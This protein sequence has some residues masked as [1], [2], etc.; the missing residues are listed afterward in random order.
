MQRLLYKSLD[1]A[2]FLYLFHVRGS[3]E[4]ALDLLLRFFFIMVYRS[5]VLETMEKN[6]PM[7]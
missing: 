7:S 6:N 4:V 3:M 2:I 5:I 1:R